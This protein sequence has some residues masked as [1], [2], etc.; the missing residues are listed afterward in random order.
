MTERILC[1]WLEDRAQNKLS[2]SGD[3]VR[4]KVMQVYNTMQSLGVRKSL[5]PC[6]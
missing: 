6:N 5:L 1:L 2:D 4:E 3:V